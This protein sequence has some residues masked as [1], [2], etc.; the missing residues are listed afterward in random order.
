MGT[1]RYCSPNAHRRI[2]Q[3][4]RDDCWSWLFM[5]VELMYGKLPWRDCSSK[6]I[7]EKKEKS[8]ENLFKFGPV[9]LYQA[10]DHIADLKY[11]SRPDY[12]FLRSVIIKICKLRGFLF[13][14]PY[15]F[16]KGGVAHSVSLLLQSV[17]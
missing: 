11:E 12:D 7:L 5:L 4:R 17:H 8:L 6:N 10:L 14:D 2:E 15:D 13:N 3:G 16:E 1:D 9:E